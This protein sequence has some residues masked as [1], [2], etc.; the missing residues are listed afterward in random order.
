MIA[1][2][3][4]GLILIAGGLVAPLFPARVRDVVSGSAKKA[5][6]REVAGETS[7]CRLFFR[8]HDL[9]DRWRQRMEHAARE[10]GVGKHLFQ[11]RERVSIA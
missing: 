9:L 8:D 10:T 1:E 2:L 3:S 7:A 5:R 11:L 6:Y 4:P